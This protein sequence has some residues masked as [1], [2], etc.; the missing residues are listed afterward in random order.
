VHIS[1]NATAIRPQ[2][3]LA[4]DLSNFISGVPFRDYLII[5]G[6]PEG[7]RLS[8]GHDNG[9][10]TW[11]LM[12]DELADLKFLPGPV[13]GVVSLKA[14]IFRLE[15]PNRLAQ[16]K[17]QI[18][19]VLHTADGVLLCPPDQVTSAEAESPSEG[20]ASPNKTQNGT[21]T[22]T[23]S[24]GPGEAT[25]TGGS[26]G[27]EVDRATLHGHNSRAKAELAD[28]SKESPAPPNLDQRCG[29]EFRHKME[30]AFAELQ[31]HAQAG[32]AALEQRRA[33]EVRELSSA[34]INQHE[35]I[36]ALKEE[37]K[38]SK[39]EAEMRVSAAEQQWREAESERMNVARREW[40]RER[41]SLKCELDS[42]R[43]IA[44]R[45]T[46]ELE[47]LKNQ[48]G[49]QKREFETRL[50]ELEAEAQRTLIGACAELQSEVAE[51]LETVGTQIGKAFE[52]FHSRHE[53]GG[54]NRFA[55]R[56]SL[57]ERAD[58]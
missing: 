6:L 7:S 39:Q 46:A 22:M 5:S 8:H 33:N 34:I 25:Q 42:Q 20:L 57:L 13:R 36:S 21:A 51:C 53:L 24:D 30:E 1:R 26:R 18:S 3:Q 49:I 17:R 31:K 28:E 58:P 43:R 41:D 15:G 47:N 44:E 9:D 32:L 29:E 37:A 27:A 16:M 40:A 10:S 48:D 55:D 50:K 11:I 54:S 35:L 23:R 45:L 56:Q 4:I 19:L 2:A 14:Q 52:T 38:Q 12:S